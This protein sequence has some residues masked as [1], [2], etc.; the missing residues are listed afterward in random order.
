[1][2]EILSLGYEEILT[3]ID[4]NGTHRD[5]DTIELSDDTG[6]AVLRRTTSDASVSVTTTVGS[7]PMT[8]EITVNGDDSDVTLNQTFGGS[9]VFAEDT[10][11]NEVTPEESFTNVTLEDTADQL[12][13]E[14]DIEVPQI[15]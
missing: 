15:A 8:L 14:H 5:F 6:A 1:M 3:A 13:V 7:N 12:V 9:T 11:G 4:P 2:A 10:D